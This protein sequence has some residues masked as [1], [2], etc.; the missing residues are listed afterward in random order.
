MKRHTSILPFV[1]LLGLVTLLAACTSNPRK[2]PAA[3]TVAAIGSQNTK[4][5]PARVEESDLEEYDVA[6]VPDPLEPVNRVTFWLNHQV[7]RFVLRPIS[8]GYEKIVP[9]PVRK[10]IH[11][12]YENVKFPVRLVNNALQGN[13]TRARQELEKFLINSSIGVGGIIKQSDRIPALAEVPRT[14][15]GST[16]AKW[17][18]T[19]G[20]YLV[21]PLLGPSTF[22]D[23]V[24]LVGDAA[25]NPVSWVTIMTGEFWVVLFPYTNTL[26]SLPDQFST[27][28]SVTETALDR[29]LAA[30]SAYIQY[31]KQAASR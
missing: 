17:G 25:L 6:L 29:Y 26:R 15:T 2:E 19:S 7:Y 3:A 13:F 10:G 20:P 11:N 18:V 4:V 27:Y 31:R 24:G 21:I 16:F 9:T 8:K 28:D 23:T 12:A 5:K 14:D 1:I 22:R 30:R